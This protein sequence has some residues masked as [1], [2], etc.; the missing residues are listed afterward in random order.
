MRPKEGVEPPRTLR[1]TR[2]ST[3]RVYQF[4]H[5]RGWEPI[6]DAVLAGLLPS[7]RVDTLRTCVP[8]V[9]RLAEA[10]GA[11][12][13]GERVDL[14]KRQKEI[15][16][17][18]R[19]YASR[20]GYP[21]TVREI[22]KAVGPAFVLDRARPPRQPGEGGAAAAR[23][24]EAAGDRAPGRSGE[25]RRARAGAPGGRSRRRRRAGPR[26]GEHR[27]VRRSFLP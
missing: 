15:F 10:K 13:G 12:E 11:S 4:R 14:T 9:S 16:D 21:P 6:L 1:S 27:G 17:F 23:P 20:Y 3:L 7:V 19:R 22:G 18:I 8:V 5:R 2:P 25:A 24:D 26:R